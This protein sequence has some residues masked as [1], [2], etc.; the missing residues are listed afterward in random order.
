VKNE[1]MMVMMLTITC[2]NDT[3]DVWHN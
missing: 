3:V 1:Q 2:Y